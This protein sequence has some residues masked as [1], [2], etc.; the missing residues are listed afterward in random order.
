MGIFVVLAIIIVIVIF[1][2]KNKRKKAIEDL[3]NSNAYTLAIKIK[4]ELEKKGYDFGE[5][6]FDFDGGYA[7]GQY[8]NSSL[9][10]R[11]SEYL[12]GLSSCKSIFRLSITTTGCRYYG[13][14]NDNI[15][16]FVCLKENS[17]DMP[18][19]IKI[20]AKVIEDSGYGQSKLVE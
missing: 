2:R 1:V 10:I 6:S 12:M 9:D 18:E 4:D 17:Q 15:G 11:F 3:K 19:S 14:E 8:Y 13:I 7:Y 20:A 16:I 5:P